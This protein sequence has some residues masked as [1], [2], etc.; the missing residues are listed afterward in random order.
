MN[1]NDIVIVMVSDN[2]ALQ[3]YFVEIISNT[4]WIDL[5]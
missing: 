4:K 1:L 2:K 3:A 5:C